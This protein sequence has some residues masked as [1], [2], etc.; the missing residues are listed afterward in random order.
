MIYQQTGH[1]QKPGNKENKYVMNKSTTPTNTTT[2]F[3]YKN[4]MK[5]F[6]EKDCVKHKNLL[7]LNKF[8]SL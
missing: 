7:I 5:L 6:V 2:N 1:P 4:N 8:L 3:I